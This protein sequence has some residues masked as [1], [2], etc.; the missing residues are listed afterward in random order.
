MGLNYGDAERE[1]PR[2]KAARGFG[3][4]RGKRGAVLGGRVSVDSMKLKYE[5]GWG[6]EAVSVCRRLHCLRAFFVTA[7]VAECSCGWI[8]EE[9]G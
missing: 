7:D 9:A 2:A 3:R 4:G 6:A 1:P 8:V 5:E